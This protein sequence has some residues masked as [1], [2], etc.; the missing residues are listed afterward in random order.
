L[1]NKTYKEAPAMTSSRI[2]NLALLTLIFSALFAFSC[3]KAVPPPPPPAPI[4]APVPPP[5][6]TI[7]LR[8]TPETVER[9]QAITLN[10]E[11]RNAAN[12]QI[13]PGVGAV[14]ATGNRQVNPTSSVTYT[15]TATGPGGTATDTARVTVNV[16]PPPAPRPTPPP[17]PPPVNISDLFRNNVQDIMFDY[18]KSDIRPDQVSRLQAN[19]SFLRDHPE[20]RFTV[21]GHADER[22]SQEYN[23]GLGD[24]RANAVKEFLAM[25]GVAGNRVNTVSY[26]EERQDCREQTEDCYQRNRRAHFTMN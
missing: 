25:N 14:M 23:L 21:E 9:G 1:V 6:P 3:K 2:K 22:G 11:A 24:K 5:A 17:P 8:A 16:P 20:V 15:A 4:A 13:E 12:V 7:T 18:D 19:A 26:G 10:W